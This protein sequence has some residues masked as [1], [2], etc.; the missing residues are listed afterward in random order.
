MRITRIINNNVICAVNE[1]NQ[2]RILLGSGIGFQK[3]KGDKVDKGK[4]EKEFF[5][6][7]KNVAGKLYSLLAQIPMEHMRVTENIIKYAK[8]TLNYE[9]NENIYILLTDHIS[10]S[11]SRHASGMDF[12]N[13]FLWE[14]K[15][16]Y[17]DEFKVG[18]KALSIIK[19]E[20]N[21][22]LPEDEAAAIAM[23]IVNSELGSESNKD[24]IK[25]TEFIQ[26]VLN[27]I[28]YQYKI[29]FDEEDVYYNR[30]IT[31]LKF[32]AYRIL[33]GNKELLDE[34]EEFKEIVKVRYPREYECSLKIGDLI[35][36]KYNKNLSSDELIYL[37]VH[38]KRI[39]IN[40]KE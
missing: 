21:V 1:R 6:K 7:S 11:I 27:I 2:E 18:L 24:V 37:T 9:F 39:T 31:H 4:I 26:N 3:K 14:V 13:A 17:C 40:Q 20:L 29:D 12:S 35:K 23:H 16:F 30:F 33:N 32:F 25:I 28:R 5:L 19:E 38:I 10:F 15:R 34:D 36:S 8:E 22:E